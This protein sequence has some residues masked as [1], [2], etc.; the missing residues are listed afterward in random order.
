VLAADRG[1]HAIG[2]IEI[3]LISAPAAPSPASPAALEALRRSVPAARC[4][5]L[6][7][8][9]ASGRPAALTLDYLD[10]LALALRVTPGGGA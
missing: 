1:G 7:A 6:L 8:A 4:L 9:L 10:D 5:P 2:Q 3:D